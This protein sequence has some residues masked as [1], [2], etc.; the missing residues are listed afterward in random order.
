MKKINAII[1]DDEK[2]AR[3]LL[4]AMLYEYCPE[5][6]VLETCADLT[7]GIKAI[8]KLVPDIVF[9]D[10]EMPGHSGL[11][12]LD[13]FNPQEVNFSIVFTTAYN[14]YAIQAFKLSAIDYLLKPIE[15]E[16]LESAV[17]KH[18][19]I[20]QKRFN[21]QLLKDNLQT[22]LP[23]KI[24]IHSFNTVRYVDLKDIVYLKAEGAYCNIYL[25]DKSLI[26]ASKNLKSFE[27][28]LA[29]QEKFLRCQKSYIINL[30][31]VKEYVKSDGG[32]LR[33]SF[34]EEIPLSQDKVNE[35]LELMAK[36]G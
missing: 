10:I 26:T 20:E 22:V 18:I 4:E 17:K 16:E 23:K 11:E 19:D 6:E 9:L 2:M 31:Y 30:E 14:Q 27:S 25:N 33:T 3:S 36:W 15:P 35:F 34:D 21:Y 12:L 28:I 24:A 5:V 7:S 13:F 1:I 32:F 8:R 29:E